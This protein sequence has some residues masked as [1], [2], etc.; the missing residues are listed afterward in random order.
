[1]ELIKEKDNDVKVEDDVL[2]Y[3]YAKEKYYPEAGT[4]FLI[5]SNK[6]LPGTFNLRGG[7]IVTLKG[8]DTIHVTDHIIPIDITDAKE[9]NKNTQKLSHSININ[10]PEKL[11]LVVMINHIHRNLH[12]KSLEE[13]GF[14]KI[15]VE[16]N[17]TKRA[18]L[19]QSDKKINFETLINFYRA[20]SF[21]EYYINE[22]SF[23]LEEADKLNQHI[24]ELETLFKNRKELRRMSKS[25]E[26]SLRNDLASS[27]LVYSAF[28][29][30]YREIE[31]Y[32]TE[33]QFVLFS[34]NCGIYGLEGFQQDKEKNKKWRTNLS[35]GLAFSLGNNSQDQ[36]LFY[37]ELEGGGFELREIEN[38]GFDNFLSPSL[39]TFI[40][41]Y[42]ESNNQVSYG[43]SYGLGANFQAADKVNFGILLG[44]SIILGKSKSV[45]INGGLSMLAVR[46]LNSPPNEIGD[47]VQFPLDIER[48]S[49][50][51]FQPSPFISISYN[52][53][54]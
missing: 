31:K 9:I 7:Y 29:E 45:V 18:H 42:Y 32:H 11:S 39:T 38:S 19:Q 27:N 54:K 2:V 49:D 25:R 3:L 10:A 6:T 23:F 51:V 41:H 36:Q 50:K 17:N 22:N 24:S 12:K 44:G 20:L 53:T 35:V 34:Y 47:I 40:T 13:G 52:L 26:D 8:K 14:S 5:T 15:L 1:M 43:L 16:L 28:Q 30:T 48:I 46:R 4:E 21:I 33:L 37:E